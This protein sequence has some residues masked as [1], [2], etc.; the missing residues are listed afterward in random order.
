MSLSKFVFASGEALLTLIKDEILHT[1][2]PHG[3]CVF[4]ASDICKGPAATG[5]FAFGEEGL[6]PV[7]APA[8]KASGKEND[9]PDHATDRNVPRETCLC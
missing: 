4:K 3:A 6:E 8:L 2:R 1:L 7:D 5:P 9:G